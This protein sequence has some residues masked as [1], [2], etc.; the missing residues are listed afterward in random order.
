MNQYKTKIKEVIEIALD[1]YESGE[2]GWTQGDLGLDVDGLPINS[3]SSYS[4]QYRLS[5]GLLKKCCI[6][7]SMRFSAMLCDMRECGLTPYAY[8][9]DLAI[10]HVRRVRE[11]SDGFNPSGLSGWNDSLPKD[12]GKDQVV[13]LLKQSLESLESAN[14]N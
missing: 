4:T 10:S 3:T 13:D 14:A 1:K 8:V 7:G 5:K 6:T 9:S 12:T 2:W 11:K